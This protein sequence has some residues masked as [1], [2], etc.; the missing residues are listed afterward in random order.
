MS[1]DS[2]EEH[3]MIWWQ[4]Y[5]ILT[6]V[7]WSA[8]NFEKKKKKRDRNRAFWPATEPFKDYWLSWMGTRNAPLTA[9]N[10]NRTTNKVW[11]Q[12]CPVPALCTCQCVHSELNYQYN[13]EVQGD[14]QF[15]FR[16]IL[17]CYESFQIYIIYLWSQVV[18]VV[19]NEDISRIIILIIVTFLSIWSKSTNCS[20]SLKITLHLLILRVIPPSVIEEFECPN[21]P[22]IHC[23]GSHALAGSPNANGFYMSNQAKTPCDQQC[24]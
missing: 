7:K 15:S 22:H 17:S 21:G 20:F 23:Q 16:Q 11:L 19:F 5:L 8:G 12:N 4:L 2:A 14:M 3:L 24:Q 9:W 13:Q 1:T 18:F 10:S 6:K